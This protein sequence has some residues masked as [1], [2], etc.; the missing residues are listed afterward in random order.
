MSGFGFESTFDGNLD[1]K[2]LREAVYNEIL[3]HLM[4]QHPSD[5]LS[6]RM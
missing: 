4:S 3:M 5:F 1:Q 2:Q 6:D